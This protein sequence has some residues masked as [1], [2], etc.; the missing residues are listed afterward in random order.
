MAFSLRVH[1]HQKISGTDETR[2][3]RRRP[4]I[5]LGAENWVVFIQAGEVWPAEGT[6]AYKRD[7]LPEGFWEEVNKCTPAALKEVGFE[8]PEEHRI[9]PKRDASSRRGRRGA[10]KE[11]EE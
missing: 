5:R 6:Q 8:I 9:V 11:T 10:N 4:Y 2:I 7:D 1:E 3:I